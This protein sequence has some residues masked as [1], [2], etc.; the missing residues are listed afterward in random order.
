MSAIEGPRPAD[1][2]G[3]TYAG[4]VSTG[5][6]LDDEV[7][8]TYVDGYEVEGVDVPGVYELE[9][10]GVYELECEGV[11]YE[12]LLLEYEWLLL[13]EC[14]ELEYEW[15]PPGRALAVATSAHTTIAARAPITCRPGGA[16]GRAVDGCR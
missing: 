16:G 10:D 13:L 5:V 3:S 6:A 2:A 7:P 8:G 12:W 14:E 4:L 15:P 11:E 1:S 9:C